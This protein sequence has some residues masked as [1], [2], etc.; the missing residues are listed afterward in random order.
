MTLHPEAARKDDVG[1][2]S[3][4][5]SVCA[6]D[7][8]RYVREALPGYPRARRIATQVLGRRGQQEPP[9]RNPLNLTARIG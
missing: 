4:G 3:V 9:K 5:K 6:G 2:G 8:G 7:S 1:F